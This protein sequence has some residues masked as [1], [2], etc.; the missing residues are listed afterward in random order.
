MPF[1]I[2]R[3]VSIMTRFKHLWKLLILGLLAVF[4]T[5]CGASAPITFAP[6][7]AHSLAQEV[8]RWRLPLLNGHF[9]TP[10]QVM[11]D[12][13]T[14]APHSTEANLLRDSLENPSLGISSAWNGLTVP[15][16]WLTDGRTTFNI[17]MYRSLTSNSTLNTPVTISA[18]RVHQLLNHLMQSH[19]LLLAPQ[20]Y[21][22]VI[23]RISAHQAN[24]LA[25]NATNLIENVDTQSTRPAYLVMWVGIR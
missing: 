21:V 19:Y 14:T 10:S 4:A 3:E 24:Q 25:A 6:V 11:I 5:A 17:P 2:N 20:T 1:K 12:P 13:L 18:E 15:A 7:S 16:M 8:H 22:L 9:T 23:Q